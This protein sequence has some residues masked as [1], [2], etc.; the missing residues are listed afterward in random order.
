M[1]DRKNLRLQQRECDKQ[2]LRQAAEAM[3]LWEMG[4]WVNPPTDEQ[5]RLM[6]P[7]PPNG[8]YSQGTS[9]ANRHFG[10]Y[11]AESGHLAFA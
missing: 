6:Y 1:S 3:M 7:E 11:D 9:I 2:C 4:L 8:N 10:I 5:R